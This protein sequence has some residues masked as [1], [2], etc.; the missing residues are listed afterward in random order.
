MNLDLRK[1]SQAVQSMV[2][3]YSIYQIVKSGRIKQRL[4]ER[5][6]EAYNITTMSFFDSV[7][8]GVLNKYVW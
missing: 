3:R 4:S 2:G 7:N 5:F 1:K 8:I 6:S